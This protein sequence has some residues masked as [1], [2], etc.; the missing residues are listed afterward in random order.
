MP[1]LNLWPPRNPKNAGQPCHKSEHLAI[2]QP[3]HTH[4][5]TQNSHKPQTT[6]GR[7]WHLHVGIWWRW[8]KYVDKCISKL[9][10]KGLNK[11]LCVR[12]RIFTLTLL[13]WQSHESKCFIC[14]SNF[15][16]VLLKPFPSPSLRTSPS[17]ALF[18]IAKSASRVSNACRAACHLRHTI[19]GWSG[20]QSKYGDLFEPKQAQGMILAVGA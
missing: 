20:A 2:H 5:N 12:K 14:P 1:F 8:G 19:A 11:M 16:Q 6:K 3:T 9:E 15:F 13:Q 4:A 17:T 10:V 18:A 7:I